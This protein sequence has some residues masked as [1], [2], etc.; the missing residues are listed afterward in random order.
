MINLANLSVYFAL[1]VVMAWGGCKVIRIAFD[2]E[3][4]LQDLPLP[5]SVKV[6]VVIAS[7]VIVYCGKF[8]VD[9][10]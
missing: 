10:F 4:E 8:V 7:L 1:V 3:S 5:V 9:H 2:D 6:A